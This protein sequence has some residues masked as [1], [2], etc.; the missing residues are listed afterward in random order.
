MSTSMVATVMEI[1][2]EAE[3]IVKKAA[4]DAAAL[5]DAAKTKSQAAAADAER[6]AAA[7]VKRLEVQAGEERAKKV[8]ELAAAGKAA[9]AMVTNVSDAAFDKGVELVM[10]ALGGE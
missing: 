4:S 9:L 6:A 5:L 10:K 2:R 7:E 3:A 8:E 1:E